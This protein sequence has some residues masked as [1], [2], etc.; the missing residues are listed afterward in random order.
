MEIVPAL[1]ALYL[2]GYRYHECRLMGGHGDTARVYRNE[3]GVEIFMWRE[4]NECLMASEDV[5]AL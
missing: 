3:R 4:G 5:G 2:H 1:Q